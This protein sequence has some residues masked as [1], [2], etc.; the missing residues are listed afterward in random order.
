[1]LHTDALKRAG[2]YYNPGL[3]TRLRLKL[4]KPNLPPPSE[5][6]RRY[7]DDLS[8]I[9]TVFERGVRESDPEPWQK[10]HISAYFFQN[11]LYRALLL[12]HM[13]GD[14]NVILFDEGI[15]HNGGYQ[16]GNGLELPDGMKAL[17]LTQSPVFPSAV[18]HFTLNE[19]EYRQRISKRFQKADGRDLNRIRSGLKPEEITDIMKKERIE[20]KNKAKLCRTLGIQVLEIE[21]RTSDENYRKVNELIDS[22]N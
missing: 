8:G 20:A 11:I 2:L 7:S 18:I 10:I 16:I 13:F 19:D 17:D 5:L 22:I 6:F 21:S 14:K 9:L 3:L 12:H 4:N 15:V 1:M